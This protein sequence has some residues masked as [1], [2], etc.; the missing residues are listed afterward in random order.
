L[1]ETEEVE[2]PC[3]KCGHYEK[4][5]MYNRKGYAYMLCSKCGVQ[6]KTSTKVSA[7]FRKLCSRVAKK[8]NRTQ[9]YYTPIEKKIKQLLDKNGYR[10]GIDY[11]HNC[12]V[13]NG[14]SYYWLDFY[15]PSEHLV[16]EVDP[17]IWHTRWNREESDKRKYT[18]LKEQG[19]NVISVT[20]KDYK[21]IEEVLRWRNL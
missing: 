3:P 6:Y 18:F 13:R 5:Y 15:I 12:R 14:K 4:P 9:G 10:E 11:I 2:Y 19:L 16:I 21:R 20:E 8:P 1:V 17:K 7:N